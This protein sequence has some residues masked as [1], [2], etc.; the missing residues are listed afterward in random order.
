[1]DRL[2]RIWT[3]YKEVLPST[4]HH[5]SSDSDQI[6]DKVRHEQNAKLIFVFSVSVEF[7]VRNDHPSI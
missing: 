2:K 3:S 6:N 5:S 7:Q 1:M 4:S